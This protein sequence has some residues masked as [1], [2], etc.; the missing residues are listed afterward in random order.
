[1]VAQELTFYLAAVVLVVLTAESCIKLLNRNVFG[2]TL[3]VYITVFAWYF[4]DPFLNPEQY[5]Y[6]P[7]YLL[8]ESYGQVLLFLLAFRVFAPVATRWIV[9]RR[10]SG[11]LDAR[12]TPEQIL[13]AAGALWLILFL[14]GIY[15][16]GGDVMGAVFPLDGRRGPTMWG[17]AAVE[18]GASGFLISSGGYLFNA[19]TAFLGVLVFFQRSTAWRWLAGAMFAIT[20]PYF[21]L[22]G[23]RSHFLAAVVPFIITYLF[24]GRHPLVIR[25]AILA[26]AFV[27][28]NEGFK[29]VVAFRDTGG[30]REVLASENPYELMNED[31]RTSGLNMIQELC[32]VNVY[33]ETSGGSPAYGARYLNELLNFIPRVIWP[34]K[35][36]IGIDYAKWRGFESEHDEN[37]ELGVNT[38]VSTGMIGGGVFNFGRLLGPFAAGILMALW[39][40]LLIRWWEQRKSLLRLVL[41]MLGAGLTFNLGRDITLL[42]LWPVIFAYFFVRLIEIR[43]VA[44]LRPLPQ[45]A[46]FAPANLEPVQ[47]S[48]GRLSQ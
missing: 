45:P 24:Y 29:F 13:K 4:V 39:T 11:I 26:V 8:G 36:M 5:D 40:G 37:G 48:A 23:A 43:A 16:M 19:V 33:L 27:C 34:S 20:L 38:T 47:M 42:V 46:T 28:L 2:V 44:R 31:A 3:M 12:L 35:P 21:F 17:R 10:N 7:S 41:F 32:F 14:I 18:T 1:M 30:Y 25:L 15:R 9:G 6:L 22:A